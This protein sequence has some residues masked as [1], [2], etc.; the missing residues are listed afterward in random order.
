MG[1]GLRGGPALQPALQGVRGDSHRRQG[2]AVSRVSRC[3][4][5]SA[6][7]CRCV[8]VGWAAGAPLRVPEAFRTG[9]P[10][11][12]PKASHSQS[13]IAQVEV[14][15]VR[16]AWGATAQLRPSHGRCHGRCHERCHGHSPGRREPRAR[17]GSMAGRNRTLVRRPAAG[18]GF[19]SREPPIAATGQRGGSDTPVPPLAAEG[20]ARGLA[21][22]SRGI[23][24]Q[25]L[26]HR[27]PGP[28]GTASRTRGGAG[29]GAA[30]A[31]PEYTIRP[32][33]PLRANRLCAEWA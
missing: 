11:S 7:S 5:P 33:P 6:Q 18:G 31:G 4:P 26:A 10:A 13:P 22:G 19:G 21:A 27:H 25:M 28:R 29:S 14:I 3:R 9:L 32:P 17:W 12:A 8:G 16:W 2:S 24:P 23:T 30:R 20:L 1:R 15:V